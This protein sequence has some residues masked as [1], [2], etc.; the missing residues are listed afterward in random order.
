MGHVIELKDDV[1]KMLKEHCLK[2][3]ASG[4]EKTVNQ[5][6]MEM[7]D[8]PE[9]PMHYPYHHFIIP[10]A[11]LTAAAIEQHLF[12]GE[13]EEMLDA[14]IG[15]AKNVLGG[16]CGNYGACGAGVGAG[17]FLSVFTDTSPMS[18]TSW[19]W[20]N[21]LTGICLQAISKVPGPRC[22]KR[23]GFLA[24]KAAVPYINEKLELHLKL[25]EN[26]VCKYADRNPDCKKELCPFYRENV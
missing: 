11:L 16:F 22:C 25:D 5:L 24:V 7:M 26:I 15:R 13:L 14:A 3:A 21:E 20:A 8:Y 19:Q 6:M 17:I 23:T 4:E 2:A 18:T 12:S 9:I 10:A 1:Y